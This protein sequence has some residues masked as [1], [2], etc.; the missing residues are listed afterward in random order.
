MSLDQDESCFLSSAQHT[1]KLSDISP[2]Y[3]KERKVSVKSSSLCG[4]AIAGAVAVRP[5]NNLLL[6][7]LQRDSLSLLRY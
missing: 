2:V 3:K 4:G 1:T 5:L 7:H 6:Q